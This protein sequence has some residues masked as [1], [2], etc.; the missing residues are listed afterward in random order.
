MLSDDV[1]VLPFLLLPLAGPEE[2]SEEENEGAPPPLVLPPPLDLR[3]PLEQPPP[4][5]Q[6]P[7]NL[8][9]PLDLSLLGISTVLILGHTETL[10]N[11]FWTGLHCLGFQDFL[12]TSSTSLMTR[13]EKRTRTS[14]SYCWKHCYWYDWLYGHCYWY[15][16]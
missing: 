10:L 13:P 16:L 8:T 1:D 4:L 7:L 6:P 2:L 11:V 9:P 15:N 14:A 12:W 5:D 3:P